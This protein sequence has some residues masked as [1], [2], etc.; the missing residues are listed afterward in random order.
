MMRIFGYVKASKIMCTAMKFGISSRTFEPSMSS[1]REET[2]AVMTCI[3]MR[4]MLEN[5]EIHL[6]KSPPCR[7]GV[8]EVTTR[9][10]RFHREDPNLE[11]S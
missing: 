7:A 1:A 6:A 8:P 5:L 4:R 11:R 10:S 9:D 2:K 3:P